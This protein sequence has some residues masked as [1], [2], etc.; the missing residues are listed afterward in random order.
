VI[1]FVK[2]IKYLNLGRNDVSSYSE[3]LIV[4]YTRSH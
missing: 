4:S 1:L 2:G 3:V